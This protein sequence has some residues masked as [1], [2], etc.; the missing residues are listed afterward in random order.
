MNKKETWKIDCVN[1]LSS[2]LRSDNGEEFVNTCS[3]IIIVK[4]SYIQL[5]SDSDV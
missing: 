2:H 1:D 3:K 5:F 4:A